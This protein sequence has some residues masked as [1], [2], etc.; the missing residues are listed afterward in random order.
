MAGTR[1]VLDRRCTMK[2]ARGRA[3]EDLCEWEEIDS[4]PA[5]R[6]TFFTSTV[7][8]SYQLFRKE[9]QK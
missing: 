1:H 8:T 6:E 3:T 4:T 5:D 7:E 9:Q 2:S